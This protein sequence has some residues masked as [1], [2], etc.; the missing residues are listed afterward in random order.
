MNLKSWYPGSSVT[1]A[2]QFGVTNPATYEL[3]LRLPDA[4][5]KLWGPKPLDP[6]DPDSTAYPYNIQ[7]AN[8]DVWDAA[9]GYNE[10]RLTLRVT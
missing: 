8:P 1:L 6:L 5:P 4:S 3:V 10:L 2:Q 9:N 7:L